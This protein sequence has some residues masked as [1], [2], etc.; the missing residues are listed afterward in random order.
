MKN[1]INY[2]AGLTLI[3]IMIGIVITTIMM[4]AVYTSYSVVN[5]SYSQVSDKAKISRASRDIVTMLMR[6]VRMAGFKY[7]AGSHEIAQYASRTQNVIM[8]L[9]LFYQKIVTFI[10]IMD[11]MAILKKVIIH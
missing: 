1:R 7:Y 6:D 9:G 11:L 2:I 10:L 4:A 5:Q 8:V 3:E